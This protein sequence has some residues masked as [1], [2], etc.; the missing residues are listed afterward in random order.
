MNNKPL[1]NDK[2]GVSGVPPPTGKRPVPEPMSDAVPTTNERSDVEGKEPLKTLKDIPHFQRPQWIGGN[3]VCPYD[4]R[5]ELGIRWVKHIRH[6]NE[7]LAQGV[8]GTINLGGEDIRVDML[9]INV[10]VMWINHVFN[11]TEE[12]LK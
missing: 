10:I 7:Q 9:D 6:L 4:L 5:A 2:K 11:L 8:V 1:P 12:D 3:G